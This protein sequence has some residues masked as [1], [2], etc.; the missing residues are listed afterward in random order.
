MWNLWLNEKLAKITAGTIFLE[1]KYITNPTITPEDAAIA[2]YVT[3][4]D[5]L[6]NKT[7]LPKIVF[8]KIIG[9][10]ADN[11]QGNNNHRVQPDFTRYHIPG[12]KQ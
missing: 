11:V 8:H 2:A 10:P 3:L 12:N 1:H 7:T 9:A 6:Q 5:K 4:S